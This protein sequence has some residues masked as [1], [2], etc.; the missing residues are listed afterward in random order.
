M[1]L[2]EV[3]IKVSAGDAMGAVE[4]VK[5]ASDLYVPAA[6]TVVE[7]NRMLEERPGLVNE[8]PE[9]EGWIVR[10][11]MD[12]GEVE[13]VVKGGGEGDGELLG[14]DGYKAFVEEG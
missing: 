8:S 9:G 6:G 7:V 10:I 4:S 13:R 3:G 5:S 2:P 14:E 11:E 12:R 1:E